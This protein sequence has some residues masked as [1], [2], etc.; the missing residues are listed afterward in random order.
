MVLFTASVPVVGSK[1]RR[2][3]EDDNVATPWMSTA[4]SR[5]LL[6]Y[7]PKSNLTI[8]MASFVASGFRAEDGVHQGLCA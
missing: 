6:P 2:Q 4:D 8:D 3:W 5:T 1:P 7:V